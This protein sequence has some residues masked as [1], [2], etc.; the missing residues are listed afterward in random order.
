MALS[1]LPL[2]ARAQPLPVGA[3]L[4]QVDPLSVFLH[5]V[6]HVFEGGGGGVGDPHMMMANS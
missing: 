1:D 4:C 3:G 5:Q 6:D 2:A